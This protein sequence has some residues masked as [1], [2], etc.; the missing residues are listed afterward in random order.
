MATKKNKN[1]KK[2]LS[3]PTSNAKDVTEKVTQT[4]TP[5][6]QTDPQERLKT[7]LAA[8]NDRRYYFTSADKLTEPDVRTVT[9]V[10]RNVEAFDKNGLATKFTMSTGRMAAQAGH[11]V[12]KLKLSYILNQEAG[13]DTIWLLQQLFRNAITNIILEARDEKELMHIVNLC[14][15]S[16]M[17][18]VKY[19]DSS[20]DYGR[21]YAP[22]TAISIGPISRSWME[23]ITD[24]LPLLA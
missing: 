13:T 11:A 17:H 2:P 10:A 5:T 8:M 9:V 18:L 16:G 3:N 4:S 1:S 7:L 20:P 24:Y 21:G 6:T 22:L 12:S 19:R 14:D 15:E 23:G